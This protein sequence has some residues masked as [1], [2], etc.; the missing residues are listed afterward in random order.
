LKR[1]EFLQP[2]LAF[3]NRGFD[4]AVKA[5]FRAD[6]DVAMDPSLERCIA[7]CPVGALWKENGAEDICGI[8]G[9]R[10]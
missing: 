2:G 6:M 3:G 4:V 8:R 9:Q 1:L 5:P 10:R 7:V